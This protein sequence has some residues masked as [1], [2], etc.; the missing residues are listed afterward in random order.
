M[1]CLLAVVALGS[2]ACAGEVKTTGNG[3]G[4]DP[5]QGPGT[6]APGSDDIDPGAGAANGSPDAAPAIDPVTGCQEGLDPIYAPS[7]DVDDVGGAS[8]ISVGSGGP[9]MTV[10]CG[11]TSCAASEVGLKEPAGIRCVPAPPACHETSYPFWVPQVA[12]GD[13]TVGGTWRCVASC[14]LVVHYGALFGGSSACA[15]QPPTCDASDD[16]AATFRFENQAWECAEMCDGELYDP[17]DYAGGTVCV[18][19]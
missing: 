17:V 11:T 6:S 10:T 2:L 3:G 5:G 8:G 16:Q 14:Q 13:S 15:T 7:D 12:F 9:P 4:D 1:K 18:P 19:C